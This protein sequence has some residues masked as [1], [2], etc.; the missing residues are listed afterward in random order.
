[1]SRT[2]AEAQARYRARQSLKLAFFDQMDAERVRTMVCPTHRANLPER[3]VVARFVR[4]HP[5]CFH[6][7]P[8]VYRTDGPGWSVEFLPGDPNSRRCAAV[9]LAALLET[10]SLPVQA[11]GGDETFGP[12]DPAVKQAQAEIAEM[13]RLGLWERHA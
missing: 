13:K 3:A 8:H 2:N 1:M 11:V 9:A 10:T 6:V 12:D 4:N 7:V 5:A